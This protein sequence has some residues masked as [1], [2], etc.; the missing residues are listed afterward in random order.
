MAHK[1]DIIKHASRM[2]VEQGI[3]AVRMDDI[4]HTLS[5][6]KRTLYE[7]FGDKEELIYQSLRYYSEHMR[8]RRLD[9]AVD[10][11]NALETMIKNL[12]NMIDNAPI[13]SRMHRNIRRFYPTVH[14]RLERDVQSKSYN[15]LENWVDN[16][17]RNGYFE[18]KIKREVVVKLI[19]DSVHGMIITTLNEETPSKEIVGMMYYALLIFIRGL[20]TVEGQRIFDHYTNKY[21]EA[22]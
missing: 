10:S 13:V 8:E 11:V 15:D 19:H 6:S 17:V 5:V 21:F 3:K 22:E 18:E 1:D 7:M 20:C 16:C 14:E 4:A 12:R 2:F 9:Q